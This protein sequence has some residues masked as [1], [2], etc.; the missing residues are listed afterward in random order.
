M[1]NYIVAETYIH[2]R[3][4][5]FP[6][7]KS[8]AVEFL[9]EKVELYGKEYLTSDAEYICIIEDG[10]L[11]VWVLVAGV[12]IYELISGYGAFR[13]GLDYLVNDIYYFSDNIIRD[14]STKSR[15]HEET[16]IRAERRLGIP[17]K[18]QRIYNQGEY[19]QNNYN[20]LSPNEVN[21]QLG[22]LLE[23]VIKLCN[24]I[25]ENDKEYFINNLPDIIKDN[26]P[27]PIPINPNLRLNRYIIREDERRRAQFIINNT[28]SR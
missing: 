4:D 17:G 1:K 28:R 8:S 22:K 24:T 16:I 3:Y 2:L 12:T 26:L 9:K 7:I 13:S 27:E 10:S 25:N 18:I 6:G 11:K 14:A 15:I 20:N 19:I 21:E 23:D 5:P